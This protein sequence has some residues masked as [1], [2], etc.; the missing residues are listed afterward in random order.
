[1]ICNENEMG[2]TTACMDKTRNT[3]K[4]YG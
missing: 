1:M 2:G 4:D 3:Y